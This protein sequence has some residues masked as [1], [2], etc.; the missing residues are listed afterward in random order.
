M[1]EPAVIIGNKYGYMLSLRNTQIRKL[2]DRYKNSKGL[3]YNTGLSDAQ[4]NEFETQVLSAYNS[5]YK[6]QYGELFVYPGHDYQRERMNN[7]IN[8]TELKRKEA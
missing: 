1:N 8:R 2:Y 7:I 6:E 5:I 3:S 4:R